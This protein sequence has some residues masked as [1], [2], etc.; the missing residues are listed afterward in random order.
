[1]SAH[2]WLIFPVEWKHVCTGLSFYVIFDPN[3]KHESM[4][5]SPPPARFT[6]YQRVGLDMPWPSGSVHWICVLMAESLECGF[7][8]R[9][10]PWCFMSLRHFTIIASLYPGVNGY[11]WGQSWLCLISPMRWN[12]SNWAVY[13][14][15]S[16]DGFRNDLCAWWAGVIMLSAVIPHVRA[17]EK[18]L[19]YYDDCKCAQTISV[20]YWLICTMYIISSQKHELE[21]T[22]FLN[23]LF[24]IYPSHKYSS[25]WQ[26]KVFLALF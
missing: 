23:N 13:S 22:F 17:L 25:F 26:L 7:E 16:W 6:D 4:V 3:L 15:G 21:C 12:D 20:K 18:C 10:R 5:H 24:Q 1:M 11:L 2:P 14:P 19:D 9:P 8:P